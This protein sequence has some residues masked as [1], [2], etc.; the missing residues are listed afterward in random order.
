VTRSDRNMCCRGPVPQPF[1]AQPLETRLNLAVTNS[2]YTPLCP[3]LNLPRL[4][5]VHL[6]MSTGEKK[7]IA[8]KGRNKRGSAETYHFLFLRCSFNFYKLAR[9]AF[10]LL[11]RFQHN[12]LKHPG[13]QQVRTLLRKENTG[14][15]SVSG[16]GFYLALLHAVSSTSG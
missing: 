16:C 13:S 10:Y 4:K 2:L 15:C 3:L 5:L 6:S 1:T 8:N 7:Q 9:S 11:L 12:L 14:R